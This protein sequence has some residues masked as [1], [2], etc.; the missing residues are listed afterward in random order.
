MIN[1]LFNQRFSLCILYPWWFRLISTRLFHSFKTDVCWEWF[2]W[3]FSILLIRIN[4]SNIPPIFI[5]IKLSLIKNKL[6][7]QTWLMA[8]DTKLN[9]SYSLLNL[10][11]VRSSICIINISVLIGMCCF[12]KEYA[13][14][15]DTRWVNYNYTGACWVFIQY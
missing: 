1:Y 6:K 15:C 13:F 12:I 4:L 7:H 11:Y 3:T 14:T 10:L 5:T 8:F 9:V 2:Y